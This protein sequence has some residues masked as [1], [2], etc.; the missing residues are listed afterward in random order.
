MISNKDLKRLMGAGSITFIY[1]TA[2]FNIVLYVVACGLTTLLVVLCVIDSQQAK[3]SIEL[4]RYDSIWAGIFSKVML[5]TIIGSLIYFKEYLMLVSFLLV[6]L[7]AIIKLR[8]I[9]NNER[10][11]K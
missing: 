2:M 6:M 1:V 4:D 5:F 9:K 11:T 10:N 8:M 7:Y 3:S